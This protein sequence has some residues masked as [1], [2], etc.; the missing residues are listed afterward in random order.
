M[1]KIIPAIS[2]IIIS[3]CTVSPGPTEWE[4]K[5]ADF[6]R[7]E[8]QVSENHRYLQYADGT[9]FFYLGDTAWELFHR[10]DRK[11]AEIYLRDRASKGFSVIQA[12]ALAELDGLTVPDPYGF[13][14]LEGLD[15]SHPSVK[16]GP[17]NDY[18]DNVDYIIHLANGLGM[19]VGL[20][21]TWGRYWHDAIPENGGRPVFD[22]DN[23]LKF[24]RFIGDRYKDCRII[25]IL[26]GDRNIDSQEQYQIIR[27]MA[28]GIREGAGKGQLVTFHP[29][30][31]HGSAEW[32]HDAEWIDFNMRQNG[33]SPEYTG[34]YDKTLTDYM[35]E[36][37]KPVIDGEPLY[38][39]HPIGFQPERYGHSIAAD[40][41]RQ[42][43]WD[44]FNGA[45]GHTYGHH[46]IW[47]FYEPDKD[48]TAP[49][50]PLMSWKEAL[51]QPGSIQMMHGR[52]LMESR[53]AGRR[54]PDTTI[55]VPDRVPTSVPGAGRYR[56]AATRDSDSTYAMVYVPA[57]RRFTVRTDMIR[58]NRLK[59]W[60]YNPRTG[61][62][63]AGNVLDNRGLIHFTPPEPG[64][65]T[66]WV[67]V[68][69]DAA[70]GYPPPGE[71]LPH[72]DTGPVR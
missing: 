51:E 20:L 22:A 11:D 68:I 33:H 7:G 43:Y 21:P 62:P 42:F 5:P 39:D 65:D 26:G 4:G 52:R 34:L 25:W 12:V 15:P 64:E 3:A 54:I 47:Q 13:L 41:R 8:L 23:A 38:E 35:R 9:P 63:D 36:P 29:S 37:P 10:L 71:R 72:R 59:I 48:R 50:F 18:W 40:V 14:P 24:G 17:D 6:S 46:S 19:Y 16:E 28:E 69:D 53:P 44:V 27:A 67:L 60:W 49:N 56:F 1:R 2:C 45:F 55:T 57:G 61:E 31:T 58:G 66:D 70:S 30:G 32:F